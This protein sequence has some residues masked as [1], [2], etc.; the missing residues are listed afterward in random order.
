VN[1]ICATPGI[2]DA[3]GI[4]LIQG[5]G[6]RTE[7]LDAGHLGVV[8]NRALASSFW[9]GED[10]IGRRLRSN[11]SSPWFE[12]SVV[13]VVEDVRQEGLER[14]STA[15]VYVPFF[16]WFQSEVWVVL[17]TE[18]VPQT[19]VPGLREQLAALD[20]HVP[21]TRVF[22]GAELY[23]LLADNRRFNTLLIGLFALVALCLVTAGT[24]GVMA[25]LVR[26]RTHELGIRAALGAGQ[27]TVMRMVI[28]KSLYMACTGILI[29]LL[30]AFLTSSVLGSLL[31]G[32]GPL[33]PMFLAGAG[34]FML[35]VATSAAA[36]PA[37]RA[38]R[39]DPVEVMRAD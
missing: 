13:G 16:P 27:T 21:L 6:I 28:S 3:M 18:G 25:Y 17:R 26:R 36:I 14:P 30:G 4:A 9:P 37:I 34:V 22:T 11:T 8:V 20:R 32:V 29:G 38:V 10:P 35:I 23:E 1:I 39:V 19:L 5:R 24:Y 15:S 33:D 31:F 12:A 2:F 7:D